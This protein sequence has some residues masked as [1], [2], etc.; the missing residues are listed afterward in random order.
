MFPPTSDFWTELKPSFILEYNLK[1]V[2]L[3]VVPPMPSDIDLVALY[4]QD[5][6]GN[7]SCFMWRL[8]GVILPVEFSIQ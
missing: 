5:L 2:S 3:T 8:F 1:K 4:L 6:F 7:Y